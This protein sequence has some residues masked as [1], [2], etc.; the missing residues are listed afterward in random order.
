[1]RNLA[2]IQVDSADVITVHDSPLRVDD[3]A[4]VRINEP[5]TKH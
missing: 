1:M 2:M 4:F 3:V 5:L